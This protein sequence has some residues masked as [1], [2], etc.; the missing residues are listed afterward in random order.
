MS[1]RARSRGDAGD[2][3]FIETLRT[4]YVAMGFAFIADPQPPELPAF[5]Q[6]YRPD[7]IALMPGRNVAIAVKGRQSS[8]GQLPLQQIRR[9]F[10]NRQDWQ[11][12]VVFAGSSALR[13]P[14]MSS[15]I[16]L[17]HKRE[18]LSLSADGHQRAALVMAWSLLEAALQSIGIA[19]NKARSAVRVLDVLA[20]EGY[21]EPDMERRLRPLVQL[22]N[23]IVHGD[24]LAAPSVED[25]ALILA[26][27]DQTLL[28][29]AA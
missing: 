2:Q 10:E 26:S 24:I 9:L 20:S 29:D 1:E 5:M 19:E 12:D 7:A 4:R 22:R 16:V 21:V 23:R 27:V 14:V 11:L 6:S 28:A 13:M 3:S 18:I 25:V 17:E 8:A 15:A